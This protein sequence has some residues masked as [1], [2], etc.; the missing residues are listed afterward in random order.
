MVSLKF[1]SFTYY[2]EPNQFDSFR[3]YSSAVLWSH[4]QQAVLLIEVDFQHSPSCA[5][6]VL[7]I[8][9]SQTSG[10]QP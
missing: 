2:S 7:E 9:Q 10:R 6:G 3:N 1:L 4:Y 5:S 8:R